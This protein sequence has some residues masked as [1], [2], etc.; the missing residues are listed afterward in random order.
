MNDLIK[1]LAKKHLITE[2][3]TE[4]GW[5]SCNKYEL[6]DAELAEFVGQV[7]NDLLATLVA[8]GVLSPDGSVYQ[9]LASRYKG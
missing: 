8:A 7:T 6:D 4:N 9:E 5:R 1:Q 3:P 2:E